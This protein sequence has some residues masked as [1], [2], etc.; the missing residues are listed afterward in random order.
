MNLLGL[1]LLLLEALNH[2]LMVEVDQKNQPNLDQ[3]V[4]ALHPLFFVQLKLN[5]QYK[6]RQ[7]QQVLK[8]ILKFQKQTSKL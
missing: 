3:N 2:Q 6:L 4:V 8:K 7:E 5:K 1:Q